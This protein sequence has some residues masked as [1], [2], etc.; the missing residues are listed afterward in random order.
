[1]DC[2]PIQ[3]FGM[4]FGS[5]RLFLFGLY[6]I[7]GHSN[8]STCAGWNSARSAGSML[9]FFMTNIFFCCRGQVWVDDTHPPISK[10][11]GERLCKVS[12]LFRLTARSD[13]MGMWPPLPNW[14]PQDLPGCLL[15]AVVVAFTNVGQKM[16]TC[17]SISLADAHTG[18]NG[19]QDFIDESDNLG[20]TLGISPVETV[21]SFK[22]L[23]V[24]LLPT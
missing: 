10:E 9:M 14:Q 12:N 21:E 18:E 5:R 6:M 1:M 3:L 24:S 8:F 17:R 23:N 15:T 13:E 2:T 4:R 20:I 16:S 11:I 7:A 22:L 19:T